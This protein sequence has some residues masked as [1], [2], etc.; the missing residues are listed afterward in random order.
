MELDV[1]IV[2]GGLIGSAAAI[3]LSKENFRVAVI[4]HEDFSFK[5]KTSNDGR[6]FALSF[7]TI[8]LLDTINVWGSLETNAQAINDIFVSDSSARNTLHYNASSV[9]DHP[10]GYM[11]ESENLK[12]QLVKI[13]KEQENIFW[14]APDQVK[15][16]NVSDTQVLIE[17]KSGKNFCAPLVLGC[18]GRFSK[19]RDFMACKTTPLHYEQEA[20]VFTVEHP[21]DHLGI[22]H[23]HFLPQGPFAILPLKGKRSGVVWSTSKST[24]DYL[25]SVSEDEFNSYLNHIIQDKR[26][27]M[28]RISPLSSYPLS[29]LLVDDF[30][31][32]RVALLGDAA[33]VMHPVAGQGVNLGFRD[34]AVMRDVLCEARSIG[35]DLGSLTTLKNYESWRQSDIASFVGLTDILVRLFSNQL[36]GLSF[37]RK[38]GLRIVNQTEFLKRKLVIGAMGLSGAL[39]KLMQER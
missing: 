16:F 21:N 4:D 23:E 1:V 19:I 39:P 11:V 13:A 9:C 2:G 29:A 12:S 17:T 20:I 25:K 30:V 10:M 36:K 5:E 7:A 27:F 34:V 15:S 33:H 14:C 3:S 24:A 31:A 32:P 35:S 8:R 6:S 28:S 38:L 26:G 18:D 22:A 37:V